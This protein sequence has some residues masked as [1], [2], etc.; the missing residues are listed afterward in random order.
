MR[1]AQDALSGLL[2]QHLEARFGS[3]GIC[4]KLWLW[5]MGRLFV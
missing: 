3:D 4:G 2:S 5:E 1:V